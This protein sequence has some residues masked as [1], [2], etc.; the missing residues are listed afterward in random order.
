MN[1]PARYNTH[2]LH[3]TQIKIKENDMMTDNFLNQVLDR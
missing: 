2:L 3:K 1:R